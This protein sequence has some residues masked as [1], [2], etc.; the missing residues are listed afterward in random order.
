MT[1]NDAERSEAMA[2]LD[3]WS[4]DDKR[5]AIA[6]QFKFRNFNA[7]FGWMSRVA[8]LAEKMNHHPEWSNV[9]N[10]VDVT[11]T[12]HDASGLTEKDIRMAKAMDAYAAA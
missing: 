12:T 11:L 2:S 6:K 7:A 9:Y 10:R 4:V 8:M 3:G 1:L 5:D